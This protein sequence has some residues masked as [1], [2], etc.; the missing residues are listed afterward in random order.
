M[1][2]ILKLT[3][4][5]LVGT[6]IG[7]ITYPIVSRCPTTINSVISALCLNTMG[8]LSISLSQSTEDICMRGIC[9]GCAPLYFI[10]SYEHLFSRG[11]SRPL[12]T[13]FYVG[14]LGALLIIL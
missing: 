5:V 2:D 6:G 8:G 1:S 7:L 4:S 3:K 10:C 11:Y 13:A 14:S 9:Y 12:T